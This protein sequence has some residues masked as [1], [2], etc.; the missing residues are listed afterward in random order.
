MGPLTLAG[1]AP[2]FRPLTAREI[3]E[4]RTYAGS[5]AKRSEDLLLLA[6]DPYFVRKIISSYTSEARVLEPRVAGEG[7]TGLLDRVQVGFALGTARV[8]EAGRRDDAVPVGV[9][10]P[11]GW[12]FSAVQEMPDFDQE[13]SRL[14]SA[15]LR[16][17][18]LHDEVIRVHDATTIGGGRSAHCRNRR[19]KR[20]RRL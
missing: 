17:I 13:V 16:R 18:A 5:R 10:R 14:D 20:S 11:A 3:R 6:V 4:L 8:L 2:E 7:D 15:L 12:R 19:V 9:C 1:V